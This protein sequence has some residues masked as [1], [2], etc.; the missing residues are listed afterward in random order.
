M[1]MCAYCGKRIGDI[2]NPLVQIAYVLSE[3]VETKSYACLLCLKGM[4]DLAEE[5]DEYS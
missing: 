4:L 3:L 5:K 1:S 2:N